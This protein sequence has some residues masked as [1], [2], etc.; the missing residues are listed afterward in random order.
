MILHEPMTVRHLNPLKEGC[1]IQR[2]PE[3][4]EPRIGVEV[5]WIGIEIETKRNETKRGRGKGEEEQQAEIRRVSDHQLNS[6]EPVNRMPLAVTGNRRK[7]ARRLTY[8]GIGPGLL[9]FPTRLGFTQLCPV[10]DEFALRSISFSF[11]VLRLVH[12]VVAHGMRAGV[13]LG[14]ERRRARRA[15]PFP[16]RRSVR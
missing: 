1:G 14:S 13:R 6:S 16:G 5:D 12:H 15:R 8:L 2:V 7:R 11:R 9:R 3:V 10:S 4:V